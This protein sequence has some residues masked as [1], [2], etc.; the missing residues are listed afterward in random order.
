[1]LPVE[2]V[3][4]HRP[5]RARDRGLGHIPPHGGWRSFYDNGNEDRTLARALHTRGY[6][7][8]LFG[9]YANGYG[10][11]E[12]GYRA[13]HVP[14]GWN[15]FLTFATS[16]GAYYDYTLTDGSRYRWKSD[17]YSTDVLGARAAQ[18]IR[19]TGS[20]Q[21]LF[22]MFTPFAPHKPYRPARRHLS[23]WRT[24]CRRTTRRR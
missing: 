2:G 15:T 5:V 18:F 1:M 9:K 12:L 23:S 11:N 20:D 17:H 8:G 4:G 16:S 24:S 7:T 10:H 21:P 6:R 19:G 3:L 14:P 13:G 22:V